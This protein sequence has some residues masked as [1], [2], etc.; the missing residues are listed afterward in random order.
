M[1][2]TIFVVR[3]NNIEITPSQIPQHVINN[4]A[5]ATLKAVQKYFDNPAV[6][7]EYE[8]WKNKRHKETE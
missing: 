2:D 6:Q 1:P 8:A 3:D 7:K 5:R 4:V